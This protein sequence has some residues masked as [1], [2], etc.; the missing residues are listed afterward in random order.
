MPLLYALSY[1]RHN[2]FKYFLTII[3]LTLGVAILATVLTINENIIQ[4]YKNETNLLFTNEQLVV[5]SLS[6]APVANELYSQIKRR[7]PSS[8]ITPIST[9]TIYTE[10]RIAKT[11]IGTDLFLL[12][13]STQQENFSNLP[14][15]Y[16]LSPNPTE[17]LLE[18]DGNK[19]RANVRPLRIKKN[20]SHLLKSNNFIT[21][22]ATFQDVTKNYETVDYLIVRECSEAELVS[23][24]GNDYSVKNNFQMKSAAADLTRALRANLNF[25]AAI[26]IGLSVLIIYNIFSYLT[27]IRGP[28]FGILRTLGARPRQI[29]LI[30]YLEAILII[31][32]AILTGIIFS[33]CLANFSQIYFQ[34]SLETLYK[35][36]NDQL[37]FPSWK[38]VVLTSLAT[39]FT[40]LVACY[41]PSREALKL[42]I[43][44]SLSKENSEQ[45]FSNKV[46]GY[47]YLGLVLLFIAAIPIIFEL[48]DLWLFVPPSLI[49]LSLIL[50]L[51]SLIKL[52]PAKSWNLTT[53]YVFDHFS[54]NLKRQSATIA[55]ISIS[56]A[57]IVGIG[58]MIF[59]FRVTVDQWINKVINADVYLT[60]SKNFMTQDQAYFPNSFLEELLK[61]PE[62]ES[63]DYATFLDLEYNN[64]PVTLIGTPFINLTEKYVFKEKL[65]KKINPNGAFVS[66]NFLRKHKLHVND[67]ISFSFQNK[68]VK[69]KIL[70]SYIDYKS[71]FGTVTI[72]FQKFSDITKQQQPNVVSIFLNKSSK[73]PE[74]VNQ[75]IN[76][77]AKSEMKFLVTN[78]Q[79]IK[80]EILEIFDSTFSLTYNILLISLIISLLNLITNLKLLL[81]DQARNFAA[82]KAI[83]AN[84]KQISK[85]ISF[86]SLLIVGLSILLGVTLGLLFAYYLVFI[87]N[88]N[89]FGWSIKF[90]TSLKL[91]TGII[92][93]P[94]LLAYAIRF[95]KFK[96]DS[97]QLKFE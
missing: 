52:L 61:N 58:T 29:Q 50:I 68:L 15:F 64:Q 10:N 31:T 18:I 27:N 53:A 79:K 57:M 38:T 42:S 73:S 25:M 43:K 14:I 19:Q 77:L 55:A 81:I 89:Y 59:S 76:Q 47:F 71:E 4:N 20:F 37:L 44:Y 63:I 86:E 48:K 49:I 66:E 94:L 96:T 78:N 56:V 90:Q 24:L 21:D 9:R 3:S 82:L 17:E 30:I 39:F 67:Q 8:L 13:L 95:L 84:S 60:M 74:K 26:A 2:I 32:T 80:Q 11:L 40:G 46:P 92:T 88:P 85:I 87:V 7:F 35:Y 75:F 70:G 1:I 45:I 93:I 69:F 23:F 97:T 65:P 6:G 62:I 72:N 22:I 91:I 33:I 34:R 36:Q 12:N 41:L 83:G 28:D 16:S 51:P 54:S 5:R